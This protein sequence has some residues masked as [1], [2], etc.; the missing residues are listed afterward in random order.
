M[1]RETGDQ[2]TPHLQFAK[3]LSF[4]SFL[5]SGKHLVDPSFDFAPDVVATQRMVVPCSGDEN[6]A[7]GAGER[8][9]DEAR[10]LRR[11]IRVSGSMDE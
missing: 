3:R 9:E 11:G 5:A 1:E 7:L 4:R 8:G 2:Y 10:V 6:E